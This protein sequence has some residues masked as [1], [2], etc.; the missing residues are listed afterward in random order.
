MQPIIKTDD[1]TLKTTVLDTDYIIGV[2]LTE[3]DPEKATFKAE[4]V[5]VRGKDV[6]SVDT[7]ADLRL[8]EGSYDGQGAI[9]NGYYNKGGNGGG[10]ISWDATSIE[11]D[12]DG[13]V[14]EVTGVSV[15][16][17]KYKTTEIIDVTRFGVKDDGTDTTLELQTL[18]NRFAA[19][20][21]DRK[22]YYFP[23]P[24]VSYNVGSITF[25]SIGAT[26]T[27]TFRFLVPDSYGYYQWDGFKNFQDIT[28]ENS[29]VN[30]YVNPSNFAPDDTYETI[31]DAY[32]SITNNSKRNQYVINLFGGITYTIFQADGA[33]ALKDYVHMNGF[34]SA[35]GDRPIV[36]TDFTTG[37]FNVVDMF[38]STTANDPY[39]DPVESFP[40]HVNVNQIDFA[41]PNINYTFHL[42][43]NSNPYMDINFKD[44]DFFH[45]G[46]IGIGYS[47]GI[48][49]YGG[50]EFKFENCIF[51]GDITSYGPTDQTDV[52]GLAWHSR[53]YYNNEELSDGLLIEFNN[54][55]FYGDR[56]GLRMVA[57]DS[58]NQNNLIRLIGNT[59]YGTYGD[60]QWFKKSDFTGSPYEK[61]YAE[62]N[63]INHVNYGFGDGLFFND[64]AIVQNNYSKRTNIPYTLD[65][66]GSI[67]VAKGT[68]YQNEGKIVDS[69]SNF[70]TVL[71]IVIGKDDYGN[72]IVQTD[73]LAI[74]K[75][76]E[77]LSYQEF[78]KTGYDGVGLI[79]GVRSNSAFADNYAFAINM[80]PKNAVD[81]YYPIATGYTRI[82]VPADYTLIRLKAW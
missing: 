29:V 64:K 23:E 14:I 58:R 8:R 71:G 5:N 30:I 66:Y 25:E 40:L 35:T 70:K 19:I 33:I 11:N 26:R 73:G 76:L 36:T 18:V 63:K 69:D 67:V 56:Y 78:V 68:F 47:V 3:P 17:W 2:D 39:N 61:I 10:Y 42:D 34:L 59:F 37:P 43:F 27:N 31:Q 62:G 21:E 6:V 52:S 81:P 32:D 53:E 54:C 51:R 22:I 28:E 48:G 15:G 45:Q 7:I 50:Q 57:F 13:S 46:G 72:C 80:L 55:H 12:N 79:D 9:V 60:I 4:A 77:N 75:Q 44:C 82:Y 65:S 24:T 20:G 16:R 74:V 1:L 38:K 41:S 49:Q